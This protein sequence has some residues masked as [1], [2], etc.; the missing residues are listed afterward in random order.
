[1]HKDEVY[2]SGHF[3]QKAGSDFVLLVEGRPVLVQEA[4]EV[5]E[6]ALR[7]LPHRRATRV[8]R[9]VHIGSLC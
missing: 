9:V 8:T 7:R 1:M 4:D 2:L 3:V 5:P 6:A